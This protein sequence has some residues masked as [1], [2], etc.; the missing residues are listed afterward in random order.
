SKSYN[1]TGNGADRGSFVRIGASGD[2]YVAGRTFNGNNNDA[3]LIKYNSSGIQQWVKTFDTGLGNEEI[4]GMVLD[5]DE[6]IYLEGNTTLDDISDA[7][8]VDEFGNSY[9][10]LHSNNGSVNDVNYDIVLIR[11]NSDGSLAW[12]TGYAASDSFDVP[13][14]IYLVNDNLFV[15]GSTWN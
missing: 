12:Q 11:Y 4:N 1:G 10:A 7:L 9:I 14:L 3:L 15:A 13:N 2:V 8:A 6:N 5:Q